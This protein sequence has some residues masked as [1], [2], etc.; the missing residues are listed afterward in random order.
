MRH[1]I[2]IICIFAFAACGGSQPEP[3]KPA[4]AAAPAPVAPKAAAGPQ[5]LCPREEGTSKVVKYGAFEVT[6]N[7]VEVCAVSV[8]ANGRLLASDET[9]LAVYADVRD[10]DGDGVP[11]LLIVADPGGGD[12]SNSYLF[13]TTPR[14]RL[15]D[16]RDKNWPALDRERIVGDLKSHSAR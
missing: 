1:V 8:K 15:V 5:S 7:R 13:T 2:G 10:L 11:E 16:T 12:R 6:V 4:A 14:P 3:P 9:G